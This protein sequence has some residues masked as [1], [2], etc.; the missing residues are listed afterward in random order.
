M[1]CPMVTFNIVK[2]SHRYLR[3]EHFIQ[4]R[5][6]KSRQNHEVMKDQKTKRSKDQKT[7]RPKDQKTIKKLWGNL[8]Q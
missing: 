4:G 2:Y 6:M 7:E 3:M 8:I 5:I 1:I